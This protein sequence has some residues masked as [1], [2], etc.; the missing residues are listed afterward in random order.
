[1]ASRIIRPVERSLVDLSN[2]GT[3]TQTVFLARRINVAPFKEV[4]AYLRFHQGTSTTATFT[5]STFNINADGYTEED[6]ASNDSSNV[7]P[8]F[9]TL[10]VG[11]DCKTISTFGTMKVIP[12]IAP[13]STIGHF[14]S[15]LSLSWTAIVTAAGT[16]R[17][18]ISVDLICKE[19]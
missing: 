2:T 17:Y 16:V 7:T 18:M 15:L 10:L 11:T 4:T 3:G 5:S 12:V 14:G 13:G 19:F 9:Q 6:P 1:M 8:A